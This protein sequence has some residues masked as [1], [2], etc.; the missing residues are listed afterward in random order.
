MWMSVPEVS[1]PMPGPESMQVFLSLSS[2]H[3]R[4]PAAA[5]DDGA[6]DDASDNGAA[7]DASDDGAAY[8]ASDD[9]RDDAST[10]RHDE[11]V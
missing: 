5:T 8:D 4:T 2:E 9:G 7:D 1:E 10:T 6:A 3:V 11:A